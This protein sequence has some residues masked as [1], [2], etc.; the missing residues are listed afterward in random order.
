MTQILAG[1]ILC[2]AT[3]AGH[4][5]RCFEQ[6]Q[7][8]FLLRRCQNSTSSWIDRYRS[9]FHL[10]SIGQVPVDCD[11]YRID[12]SIGF[13]LL[14]IQCMCTVYSLRHLIQSVKELCVVILR[15]QV[16]PFVHIRSVS[17]RTREG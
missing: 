6:P 13:L 4:L 9:F 12:L 16:K 7:V 15:Y 1:L 14:L 10:S 17:L 8:S 11:V 5:W 2:T 3:F